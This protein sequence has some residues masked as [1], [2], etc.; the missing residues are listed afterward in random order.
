MPGKTKKSEATQTPQQQV[1]IVPEITLR[2]DSEMA[3]RIIYL[4]HHQ[5]RPTSLTPEERTA[6]AVKV[7]EFEM[8]EDAIA[9]TVAE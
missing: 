3:R 8:Y 4:A 1:L 5:I 7:R 6:L 9:A 2:A